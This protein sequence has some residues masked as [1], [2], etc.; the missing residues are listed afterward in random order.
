MRRFH[1]DVAQIAPPGFRNPSSPPHLPTVVDAGP[2][3]GVAHE[4]LGG[5]KARNLA[6]RRKDCDRRYEL[7]TGQLDQQRNTSVRG[8]RCRQRVFELRHLRFSK[9]KGR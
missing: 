9:R 6:D 5:W 2:Q 3:A 1:H 8:C 7:D 4:L